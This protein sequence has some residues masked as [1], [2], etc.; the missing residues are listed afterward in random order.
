MD[1]D[2]E[3]VHSCN[4]ALQE[5]ITSL[6]R[7]LTKAQALKESLSTRVG[8]LSAQLEG[9]HY[10]P[11]VQPHSC[12]PSLSPASKDSHKN[13][14][15]REAELQDSSEQCRSILEQQLSEV[16]AANSS[17]QLELAKARDEEKALQQQLREKVG[18]EGSI[19]HPQLSA[20]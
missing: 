9:E 2:V 6:E 1:K 12:L 14:A 20:S 17:L 11:H 18:Q 19:A 4:E 5:R 16:R 3:D 10:S 7:S 15:H 13:L 8:E